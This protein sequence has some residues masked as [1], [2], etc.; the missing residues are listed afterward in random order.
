L[1]KC[2]YR[3]EIQSNILQG[4]FINNNIFNLLETDNETKGVTLLDSMKNYYT[5]DN[6]F[7]NPNIGVNA[8]DGFFVK[9]LNV[10]P[11]VGEMNI[12]TANNVIDKTLAKFHYLSRDAEGA[13]LIDNIGGVLNTLFGV[14]TTADKMK[15]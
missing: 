3:R 14:Y 15:E 7:T 4:Q 10:T 6:L 2:T 9:V 13:T 5:Q 11:K 1:T 12:T 8:T